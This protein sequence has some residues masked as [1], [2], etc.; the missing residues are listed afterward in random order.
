L[1]EQRLRGQ[2]VQ[3]TA[4]GLLVFRQSPPQQLFCVPKL[5][6][7]KVGIKSGGGPEIIQS[8]RIEAMLTGIEPPVGVQRGQNQS[9]QI[10]LDGSA[11]RQ[12]LGDAIEVAA[13]IEQLREEV[14]RKYVL[15]HVNL[16]LVGPKTERFIQQGKRL[17]HEL[18]RAK[19]QHD[20]D[21]IEANDKRA[22]KSF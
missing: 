18:R 3:D 13:V 11:L 19:V 6:E 21:F 10:F 22:R 15:H 16:P 20:S 2:L 1:K 17:G 14:P 12:V 7:R 9:T 4:G 5:K 8:L